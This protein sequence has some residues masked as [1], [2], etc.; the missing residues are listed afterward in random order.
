MVRHLPSYRLTWP[1]LTVRQQAV[2]LVVRQA[3]R[4]GV[5]NPLPPVE[6]A[7]P[8]AGAAPESALTVRGQGPYRV[9]CQTVS[10]R[11]GS[12]PGPIVPA[13][14]LPIAGDPKVPLSVL[15]DLG[16]AVDHQTVVH[17]EALPQ[18]LAQARSNHRGAARSSRGSVQLQHPGK[19]PIQ[20]HTREFCS[21]PLQRFLPGRVLM[22]DRPCNGEFC[23]PLHLKESGEAPCR[24]SPITL[25]SFRQTVPLQQG[26]ELLLVKGGEL[27]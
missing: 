3:V 19:L 18:P 1:T 13:D 4:H 9:V 10:H 14:P 24:T 23:Q 17:P 5:D 20:R 2:Y 25:G 21:G 22:Q 6:T 8:A 7:Q 27:R 26:R 16:D 11:E 12:C 15:V